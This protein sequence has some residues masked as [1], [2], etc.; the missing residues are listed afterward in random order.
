[1]INSD[2]RAADRPVFEPLRQGDGWRTA[3]NLSTIFVS[4]NVMSRGLTLD[5]LTTTLFTRHADDPASDT[6]MQ[7]QHSACGYRGSFIDVCRVLMPEQQI[8]LFTEYHETDLA[9]R[10]QVLDAMGAD[11][12]APPT[13]LQGR[14][15][16]ATAKV[17]NVQGRGLWPGSEPF[18]TLLN[19]PDLDIHNQEIVASLFQGPAALVPG[20]A[21]DRG[22]L[23]DRSLT[24]VEVAD[25][26]NM[27]RYPAGSD[28]SVDPDAQ[29]HWAAVQAVAQL[30]A[31]DPLFPIYAMPPD[32]DPAVWGT[33]DPFNVAAYLKFWALCLERRCPAVF[34]TDEP[35]QRWSTI[36]LQ[37]RALEAPLFRVGLR[38]GSGTLSRMARSAMFQRR[39]VACG[40][41]RRPPG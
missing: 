13:V 26:L 30:D 15:F 4:G 19:P 9:L 20:E 5:G 34:S 18:T 1:M 12:P 25:L 11:S 41:L 23:L 22:L 14:A 2:V 33:N 16:K 17:R 21:G 7:M 28:G 8:A 3:P 36:D 35:P 37:S 27:L 6:Q 29:R 32:T 39:C 24:M 40:A 38:F 31:D 10:I